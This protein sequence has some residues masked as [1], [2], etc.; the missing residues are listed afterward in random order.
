M[1]ERDQRLD[2]RGAGGAQPFVKAR[3][4]RGDRGPGRV[5]ATARRREL[6]EQRV[7]ER[8]R[9]LV[10]DAEQRAGARGRAVGLG[11]VSANDALPVTTS[12]GCASL[13][14]AG[15]LRSGLLG[16]GSGRRRSLFVV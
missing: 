12:P 1:L 11:A 5:Q 8:L 10:C 2:A 13:L 4:V 14:R 6:A 15:R 3:G 16:S 9:L 7:G